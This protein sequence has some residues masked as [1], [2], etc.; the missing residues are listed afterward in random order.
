M[1]NNISW[2]SYWSALVL[3]VLFYYLCLLLLLYR[4]ALLR[5]FAAAG[6]PALPAERRAFPVE[7]MQDELKAYIEQAGHAHVV[8][9]ELLYGL[10]KILQRYAPPE[11]ERERKFIERMIQSDCKT[12]CG[13]YFDDAELG[14]LWL[15]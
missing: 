6:S 9:P 4:P 1:L 11:Q 3:I 12:F 10:Q 13:V 8:K 5:R 14:Q 7:T 15:R 2:S